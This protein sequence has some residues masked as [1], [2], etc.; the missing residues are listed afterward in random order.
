[1]NYI[2]ITDIFGNKLS[3]DRHINNKL[4]FILLHTTQPYLLLERESK[5]HKEDSIWKPILKTLYHTL[6]MNSINPNSFATV[7]DIWFPSYEL[8][9]ETMILLANNNKDIST[10][11]DDFIQIDTYMNTGIWKSV[12]PAGY[13]GIGLIAASRKPSHMALKVINDKYL[14]NYNKQSPIKI[15]NTNMNE[16]NLLSNIQI[17]NKRTIDRTK[18]LP[19]SK[20]NIAS[21]YNA[22]YISRGND[23]IQLRDDESDSGSHS[24]SYTTQGELKMNNK[25]IGVDSDNSVDLQDCNNALSQK[26]FPYKN[27]YISYSDLKCMSVDNNS[28]KNDECSNDRRDQE[29]FTNDSGSVISTSSSNIDSWITQSG[30]NVLLVEPDTPWYILKRNSMPEGL[31]KQ[32]VKELNTKGGYRNN[33]DFKSTFMMDLNKPDLGYGHSYAS[34]QGMRALCLDDCS[35]IDPNLPVFE[36]FKED[37]SESKI[38]FNSI[39]CSLLLL[40]ILLIIIRYYYFK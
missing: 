16:F 20:I 38:N 14:I 35:N 36:D 37:V 40:I 22:K 3:K 31:I 9:K 21:K 8:P 4:P 24:I 18:F 2:V 34:R 33:A 5:L 11:P 27:N 15:K 19:A 10:Y 6:Y 25:C 17:Q 13:T 1:M 28:I 7:G 23:R 26:W 32:S 39:A 12:G 30:K 29:W